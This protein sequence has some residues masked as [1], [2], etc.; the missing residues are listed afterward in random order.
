MRLVS[1]KLG[2]SL[3]LMGTV[4]AAGLQ[5]A[6]PSILASS[7]PNMTLTLPPVVIPY[8]KSQ[9]QP[10]LPPSKRLIISSVT[11]PSHQGEHHR[12]DDTSGERPNAPGTDSR[13]LPRAPCLMHSPNLCSSPPTR[14]KRRTAPVRTA[15]D[16]EQQVVNNFEKGG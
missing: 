8:P 13:C 5:R 3:S 10:R 14:P 11:E 15:I 6:T 2:N 1:G 12:H 7:T 9:M 4:Q 16:S